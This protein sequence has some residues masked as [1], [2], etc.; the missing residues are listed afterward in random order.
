MSA[1]YISCTFS[2]S[3]PNVWRCTITYSYYSL[4]TYEE[5]KVFHSLDS[6]IKWA[7]VK[8]CG[9]TLTVKNRAG[10]VINLLDGEKTIEKIGTV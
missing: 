2:E 1:R 4:F 5:T 10:Y 9:D 8:R 6:A 3:L 7:L